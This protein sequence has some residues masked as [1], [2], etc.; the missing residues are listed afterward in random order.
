MYCTCLHLAI[1]SRRPIQ[2]QTFDLQKLVRLVTSNHCEPEAAVTFL[3]LCVDEGSFQLG[4]VSCE[5]R[6]PSCRVMELN[7]SPAFLNFWTV[8]GVSVY[9]FQS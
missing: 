9:N 4:W 1:D 3:Q 2:H 7:V 8:R 5:E 6:F